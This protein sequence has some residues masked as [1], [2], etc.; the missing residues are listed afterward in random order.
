MFFYLVTPLILIASSSLGLLINPSWSVSPFIWVFILVPIIDLVLPY[1]SKQDVDL[2]EN[3]L[4]NFSILIILPCI[5]FLIVFGLIV[6]SDSSISLLVAA[7]LGAAVGMSGGSI[8]ITTAHELIHR[9]NKY[10][11]GIGVLLLVLCC[12]G[13]FRIEHVYGH[14]K[15]VATKEDPATARKGENFYFYFIR[16]VINS[17]ISSW[18]I[19]KNILDKKNI[20]T[21]SPQNRML[22]YFIL[23]IIFLFIAFFIAGINGL[24][25]VIFH[26]FVSI[27]LLELVNYIQHYGLE[28]KMQNGKYERFTDHHSWN[29]RH[30]SANWSTFN[31][32]LHAEHHQSASKPYPLLSQEEKVIEMPANYSI[33]LIM[34]L[35]PPLWFFIMDRKIDKLKTINSSA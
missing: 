7:A 19:E 9:Q 2:K 13:H 17:V 4:H 18:N 12:Y 35:I 27:T 20:N 33:M 28:R 15:N 29:S 23:E 10:M 25:F 8:G 24:I 32:G 11:R 5:L 21:L 14:H 6:V 22:H 16:C 34:A 1:L 30:I 26:S 31:L 3:M